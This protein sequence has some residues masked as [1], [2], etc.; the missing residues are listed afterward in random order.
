MFGRLRD[1]QTDS[2]REE[3]VCS[4]NLALKLYSHQKMKGKI[5]CRQVFKIHWYKTV[6]T[7]P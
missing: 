7:Q 5:V 4:V 3:C 6:G 1:K 2:E